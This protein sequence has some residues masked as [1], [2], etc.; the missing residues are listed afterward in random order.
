MIKFIKQPV[1]DIRSP[2]RT[3]WVTYRPLGVK[4]FIKKNGRLSIHMMSNAG[5]FRIR[6][7]Y[8]MPQVY[9]VGCKDTPYHAMLKVSVYNTTYSLYVW[10][11]YIE[12]SWDHWST[13]RWKV[14]GTL[15]STNWTERR[16]PFGYMVLPVVLAHRTAFGIVP[17]SSPV[18]VSNDGRICLFLSGFGPPTAP[19]TPCAGI[20]VYIF[21]FHFHMYLTA[22]KHEGKIFSSSKVL[23]GTP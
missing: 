4:Q 14:R 10:R 19:E 20:R 7:V 18:L 22:S 8:P 3:A 5:C 11:R 6:F 23:R 16:N 17:L 12:L 15:A 21:Y 9:N 1:A 2:L 13:E